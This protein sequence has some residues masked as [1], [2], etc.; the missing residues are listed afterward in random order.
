MFTISVDNFLGEGG[1]NLW[2]RLA[3]TILTGF[4]FLFV[5]C[6]DTLLFLCCDSTPFLPFLVCSDV[7]PW[8]C[9]PLS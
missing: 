8:N 3:G 9:K 5:F 4:K 6:V 1:E 7:T 2:H